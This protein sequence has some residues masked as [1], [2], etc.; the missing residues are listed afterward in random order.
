MLA[1]VNLCNKKSNYFEINLSLINECCKR[2]VPY[3]MWSIA[4]TNVNV[5]DYTL[6]EKRYRSFLWDST[7]SKGANMYTFGTNVYF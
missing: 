7:R 4:L 2:N 5:Q 6:S 1:S 3:V